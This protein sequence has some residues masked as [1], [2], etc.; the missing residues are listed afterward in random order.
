MKRNLQLVSLAEKELSKRVLE[1]TVSNW[2]TMKSLTQQLARSKREEE[3]EE[4]DF[5][6]FS[7]TERFEKETE[8]EEEE[9]EEE[10]H[11]LR[12]CRKYPTLN[13]IYRIVLHTRFANKLIHYYKRS[14][15]FSFIHGCFTDE[16]ILLGWKKIVEDGC[17]FKSYNLFSPLL[18]FSF[19]SKKN[20]ES[21]IMSV[22]FFK[23]RVKKVLDRLAASGHQV[24][25]PRAA[26][27]VR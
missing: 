10:E 24:L 3:E 5:T 20:Y 19:F 8:E 9:E 26:D 23:S 21:D 17:N 27:L 2:R 15:A 4:E 12:G 11:T 16:R 18:S 13:G 25:A 7:Q 6:H 22:Q 14:L 1:N